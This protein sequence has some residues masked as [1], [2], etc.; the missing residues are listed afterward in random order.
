MLERNGHPNATCRLVEKNGGAVEIHAFVAEHID[1][2]SL[3]EARL[4]RH[5][6]DAFFARSHLDNMPKRSRLKDG[7]W[8]VGRWRQRVRGGGGCSSGRFGEAR[9]LEIR[10]F[11]DGFSATRLTYCGDRAHKFG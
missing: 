7:R 8:R 9:L 1:R 3:I 11:G 10:H 6:D 2:S 5:E 4:L